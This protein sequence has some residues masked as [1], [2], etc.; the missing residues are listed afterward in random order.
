MTDLCH[1]VHSL[2]AV[3]TSDRGTSNIR[4][5]VFTPRLLVAFQDKD[6]TVDVRDVQIAGGVLAKARY[7][8]YGAYVWNEAA[9]SAR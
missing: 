4:I 7:P 9:R 8:V 2:V 6:F 5:P 1:K 3:L